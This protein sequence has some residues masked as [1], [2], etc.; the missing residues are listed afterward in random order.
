MASNTTFGATIVPAPTHTRP[1][2]DSHLNLNFDSPSLTPAVSRDDSFY[3][4]TKPQ[5]PLSPSASNVVTKQKTRGSISIKNTIAV[6]EKDVESGTATPL[7]PDE[8]NPFSR[9]IGVE[10]N[11]EDT[12]WPSKQT[13]KQKRKDERQLRREK[14]GITAFAPVRKRWSRLT[15][16]E[17]LM[18]KIGIALFLVGVA[19]AIGV[20]ISVAVKGTY[21][22]G[23]GHSKTI[24]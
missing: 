24:G 15:K 9:S 2:N 10:T 13:L 14:R 6:F 20:G 17:R 19:I 5:P 23:D 21:Y 12:M 7:T 22:V 8:S 3:N 1:D 18:V 16:K 11:K 4:S